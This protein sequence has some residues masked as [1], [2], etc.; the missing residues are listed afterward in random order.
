MAVFSVL[1]E[2]GSRQSL[3]GPC[4][5]S[6]ENTATPL[7][8]GSRLRVNYQVA[9]SRT[10]QCPGCRGS[11]IV[12]KEMEGKE[13]TCSNPRC[14]RKFVVKTVPNPAPAP[15]RI[16]D[17]PVPPA[18]KPEPAPLSRAYPSRPSRMY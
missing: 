7:G 8:Q 2:H 16:P 14:Q 1:R 18:P 5:R 10:I 17:D 6:T 13:V 9:M 12:T 15:P 3:D 4:S 11:G